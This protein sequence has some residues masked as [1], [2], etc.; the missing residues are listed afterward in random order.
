ML[1]ALNVCHVMFSVV[2]PLKLY[3]EGKYALSAVKQIKVTEEFMKLD[4]EIKNCNNRQSYEECATKAYLEHLKQECKCVPY[5]L[6]NYSRLDEVNVNISLFMF[7]LMIQT[8][9][10]GK[11]YD[12]VAKLKFPED[13]KCKKSCEGIYADVRILPAPKLVGENFE[14]FMETYNFYKR[15]FDKL[16]NKG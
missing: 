13:I 3:G 2:A 1:N 10:V 8:L 9:C 16:K 4:D 6:R 14:L 15:F 7:K 12:C 5:E 11:N